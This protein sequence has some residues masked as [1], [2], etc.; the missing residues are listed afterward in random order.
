MTFPP[1]AR[2]R[3]S[4]PQP[5]VDDIP[6]TVR[7]LILESRLRERVPAGGTIAVGVG[8][9][10]ITAIADDG[11]GGGRRPQGDGLPAVHRRRDGQPRRRHRR[12]PARAPGRLRHHDRG[13]GRRGQD[14][15]GHGRRSA[16]TRSACRS[17]ST[18]T[19]TRPTA[20]SCSTGSS[21]T[22]TSTRRTSRASSRCWSSAWASGRGPSQVHKLG[23]RGMKEVLPAVGKFLVENTKFALGLA[24]LENAHDV[25]AEIVAGRAGDDLR[26]RAE[27][28]R[29]GPRPDGPAAV[30]PDRRPGR[31]RARQELLGRRDGPERDRPADGR[32]PGR[33]RPARSSPAWPC[34]TSRRR[35]TATSSASASPT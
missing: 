3:Q 2:V 35:A 12:R 34:S 13:D 21:R 28:A 14:R 4:I 17:T 16:P 11:A 18:R 27:A 20:S 1:L 29:P 33:L 22:P 15:H 26:R 31:R 7:R 25:P 5:H 8:S 19:P 10:G 30:R 6:G 32:D 9:R 24:I 23:L